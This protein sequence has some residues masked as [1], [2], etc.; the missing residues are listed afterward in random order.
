VVN[1]H[2]VHYEAEGT[3][4]KSHTHGDGLPWGVQLDTGETDF[5]DDWELME[6]D[7]NKDQ[8][9]NDPF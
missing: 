8:L 2:T 7:A 9:E 1:P 6:L 4:I 3:V 5:F